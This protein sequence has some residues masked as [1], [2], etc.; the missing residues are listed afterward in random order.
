MNNRYISVLEKFRSDKESNIPPRTFSWGTMDLHNY[1]VEFQKSNEVGWADTLNYY[2]S[3]SVA[4][5]VIGNGRM[6]LNDVRKMNDN[7][8]MIFAV[9]Y[10]Q[11]E[12]S[13]IKEIE[14]IQP[15]LVEAIEKSYSDL[16]DSTIWKDSNTYNDKLI[17]AMC[18]S[19]SKD[20]A[21]MWDRYADK[22]KGAYISFNLR[23]LFTAVKTAGH[24]FPNSNTFEHGITQICYGGEDCSCV[25]DVYAHSLEAYSVA[26]TND[27]R[28]LIRTMLHANVLELLVSHKHNSFASEREY[29]IYSRAPSVKTWSGTDHIIEHEK[30][31]SKSVHAEI[32]LPHQ[33]LNQSEEEFWDELIESVTLGPCAIEETR[34]ELQSALDKRGIDSKLEKSQCPLF[35]FD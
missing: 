2:C 33:A 11:S 25:D 4:N 22:G 6:W 32:F 26:E 16:T 15:G 34:V 10:I 19:V 3:S 21:A 28:D 27:E 20:D 13:R 1:F 35:N 5:S 7:T 8:E 14:G 30:G 18:F 24:F 12:L 31:N 17:L 23:K 9:D 29:R